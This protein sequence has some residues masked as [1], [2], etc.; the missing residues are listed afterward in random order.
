[1]RVELSDSTIGARILDIDLS[2][3]LD[4]RAIAEIFEVWWA[5]GVLVFPG[6]DL[7]ERTQVTFCRRIGEI[8]SLD[9]DVYNGFSR[10]RPG[11][12]E[13]SNVE[14]D[15]SVMAGDAERVQV[16]MAT[17]AWHCDGDFK[18]VG[19]AGSF[20]HAKVVS[21]V[22]GETEFADAQAAFAALPAD[23][24]A[25]L[26]TLEAVHCMAGDVYPDRPPIGPTHVHPVV[27][28]HPVTGAKA[29]YIGNHASH[30]LG[31]SFVDGRKL[32]DELTEEACQPPRIFSHTWSVGDAVLW[33]N[34]RV[35]HRRRPWPMHEPRKLI[36]T[37]IRAYAQGGTPR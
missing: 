20:L 25:E 34:H 3:A 13:L 32:L 22:G 14:A 31:A 28:A 23:R 21:S 17:E 33:D 2:S 37:S 8:T 15:G 6:Q 12:A 24:Q 11:V 16:L 26:E 7:D 36:R 5:R 10:E 9:P 27:V 4:D 30:L 35:L 29:L 18:R 19:D 1:M